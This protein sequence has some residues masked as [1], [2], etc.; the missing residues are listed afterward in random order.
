M[1]ESVTRYVR[2]IS[3]SVEIG[4]PL[5]LHEEEI[6]RLHGSYGISWT[7]VLDN[8]IGRDSVGI[9]L[10]TASMYR[11][12][13]DEDARGLKSLSPEM[14]QQ[15]I[16]QR[17][18][19]VGWS[20]VWLPRVTALVILF[21]TIT[22]ARKPF[23]PL[24]VVHKRNSVGWENLSLVCVLHSCLHNGEFVKYGRSKPWSLGYLL[25]S[26]VISHIIVIVFS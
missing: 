11:T 2:V 16:V 23:Y 15:M 14:R 13:C 3:S 17:Q 10:L 22:A 12:S 25:D 8:G 20:R 18:R 24:M 19:S 6:V 1:L 26:V 5:L 21:S 9:L 4:Y 7:H